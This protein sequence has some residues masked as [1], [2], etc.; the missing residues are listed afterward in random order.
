MEY[1][2]YFPA[3]GDF[4][5]YPAQV[6]GKDKVLAAVEPFAFRVVAEPTNVD[7]RS[8]AYVSQYGS[9]DDV[10]G[11]LRDENVQR[12]DLDRIAFRMKDPAFFA[13]AVGLLAARHVYSHT[14]W[15]YA[16]LHGD[17]PAV[18][19]FL[20]H[21]ESFVA[22]T[23]VALRSPLLVIDPVLRKTYE[24]LEYAPLVNARVAKLSRERE[25]LNDRFFEQYQRL[26]DV[27]SRRRQLDDEELMEVTYYL[28]LQ[29]RVEEALETFGRVN[30]ESLE[31]RLQYD[32]FAA[33]L[34]F[35]R[36]EPARARETAAK[37]A[38]HPVERWREA[39]RNVVNQADEVAM[40][41]VKVADEESRE[42]RQAALAASEPSFE[43]VIEARTV[44]LD[45]QNLKQVRVNYYPMDVELSFSR[46]PFVQGQGPRST[47]IRPNET[48]TVDL[49]AGKT[50][51]EFPLPERFHRSNVLVEVVG[52]GRTSSQAYYANSL[53]VQVIEGYG[54]VR[55]TDADAGKPLPKVYVKAYARTKDGRVRFYK[56]GY[57]DLR[58][59]F[60][61]AT[62]STNELE[63]VDRFSLLVLSDDRGALVK[64]AAPPQR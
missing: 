37:Y 40:A 43:F 15:A 25:I 54:Q 34:D 33:Y 6:S 62:L 45:Y 52:A 38:D 1:H 5:H 56:D 59:R 14:L 58:G 3:P 53:R 11:F 55:V 30:A 29:D 17:A 32:Y 12:L 7:K 63:Q 16:V 57:T 22:Q 27:L 28:L 24:H 10:L 13:K 42:Q 46:N 50:A 26:L 48:Q 8:W 44:R 61:Y 35:Y 47:H 18:R 39:F 4:A 23:G 20:Q 36:S 60:D 51:F 31:T 9:D 49:P 41:D 21:A 64:E 2:F 19:E